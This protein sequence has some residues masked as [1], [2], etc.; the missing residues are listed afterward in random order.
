L[1]SYP[2]HGEDEGAEKEGEVGGGGQ[3]RQ[4]IEP[5][6]IFQNVLVHL[7]VVANADLLPNGDGHVEELG[8][9]E[10]LAE[11]CAA[12]AAHA[13]FKGVVYCR[14]GG[15]EGRHYAVDDGGVHY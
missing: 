9:G 5:V 4:D 10:I 2:N 11:K 12:A 7:L 8:E 15:G 1:Q 13:V 6:Q 3:R 14:H